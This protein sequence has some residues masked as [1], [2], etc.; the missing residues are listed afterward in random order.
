MDFPMSACGGGLRE[1]GGA[2]ITG[3]GG[4][5][6]SSG[7]PVLR[8]MAFPVDGQMV[9]APSWGKPQ[10]RHRM[11]R[12]LMAPIPA[13]ADGPRPTNGAAARP[14]TQHDWPRP[15]GADTKAYARAPTQTPA[16]GHGVSTGRLHPETMT[17]IATHEGAVERVDGILLA[18]VAVVAGGLGVVAPWHVAAAGS[19]IVG[20]ALLARRA[21]PIAA[22]VVALALAV[23][24][25]RAGAAVR[26]HE[27]RR[28]QAD[29]ALPQPARC[30]AHGRVDSSPVSIRGTLKWDAWLD[31]VACDGAAVAWTGRV[32][33]YGGPADLARNDDIAI[34]GTLA[35]PQRLWNPATGD[36]RASEALRGVVR[37][38][39]ALD[40]RVLRPGTGIVAFV[41]RARARVRRRIESTFDPDV[42]PMARALVLGESDLAPADDRAFRASG[43]SHLLAVSGMHLVLVLAVAVRVLE[44][45]FRRIEGLAARFDVGRFAAW[46]GIP[47][48]WLYAEFAGAGGST[49]RAAWMATAALAA[50]ALGR[51]TDAT[52]AF[53]L[54]MAAMAAS[55]P[56]VAFDLS[57]ALSAGATAG[58]LVFARPLAVVFEGRVPQR[59][60]A[61]ARAVATTVAATVPCVP[62]LARFAPTVP[63]G[64]VF[65]NLVAVPLGESAALPLC[66]VHA[67]MAG[68]PAAEAG[69]AVVASG[70]LTVVRGIA[71][72]FAARP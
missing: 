13:Y 2:G 51:R 38:G 35:P 21:S 60:A 59:L 31:E 3:F 62:I 6:V 66:L 49:L 22:L 64:G 46:I 40:V 45:V 14:R 12:W 7:L 37:T 52:R 28:A 29:V 72:A 23:G 27:A 30:S 56:L 26:R 5:S 57:F 61:V 63:L 24:V 70:A 15:A 33:L 50:R 17:R 32:T 25:I 55:Q 11:N 67:W 9:A 41:D 10:W 47:T 18:G 68:W 48:A 1:A 34:V 54:S 20:L 8:R 19:A 65:A 69:C 71:R 44:G 42:A 39:G 43:L 53:G 36:P 16:C 58:L 4:G